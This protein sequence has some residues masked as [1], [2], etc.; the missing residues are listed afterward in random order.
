MT[1]TIL[2][3]AANPKNTPSI[4]LDQ[5]IRDIELGLER[6]H[7]RDEFTLKQKLAARPVDVRRAMLDYQPSIVHF[8]GHGFGEE[9]IVFEDES[10]DSYPVNADVLGEFFELFSDKV[11]C[12]V[13]NACFSEIQANAIS[14]HIPFVVGMKKEIGDP[15]AIEFAVA[16]YDSL[17]AGVSFDVAYRIA[18]NAIQ[19][20]SNSE[21]Q[22]PILIRNPAAPESARASHI[23]N[24]SEMQ[25]V[26]AKV[27][28]LSSTQRR[29]LLEISTRHNTEYE[30]FARSFP[31]LPRSELSYRVKDLIAMGL[32]EFT[33][34]LIKT[35]GPTLPALTRSHAFS[36]IVNDFALL[37]EL[38][39]HQDL[40]NSSGELASL[41]KMLRIK[42]YSD[43]TKENPDLIASLL[44]CEVPWAREQIAKYSELP[45]AVLERLSLDTVDAVRRVIASKPSLPTKVLESLSL[46]NS[47]HIR[48]IVA[49]RPVLPEVVE[50]RLSR[51]IVDAVRRAIAI[52]PGLPAKII[53]SLSLDSS[54]LVRQVVAARSE[55][56]E[57][58]V[59]RLSRDSVDAV[60]IATAKRT[61][62]PKTILEQFI[63]DSSEEVRLAVAKRSDLDSDFLEKLANDTSDEIKKL[64]LGHVN[65]PDTTLITYAKR[66]DER[67]RE[68]ILSRRKLSQ[69]IIDAYSLNNPSLGEHSFLQGVCTRCG[70]TP[71]FI[72]HFK[73]SC[74]AEGKPHRSRWSSF[75]VR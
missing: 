65:C 37:E 12:V 3:L 59:E 19:W 33:T 31:D 40:Y 1:R 32:V 60:R 57:A 41:Y 45:E 34:T 49:A 69:T 10:G 26:F 54:S 9:G 14:R 29:L 36:S 56:A 35:D 63:T 20:S 24:G 5:E 42:R 43:A 8:C 44:S 7:K 27:Y 67:F 62:V 66:N 61:H 55:L 71:A 2:I 64:S 72:I 58:T 75:N 68:T 22:T 28:A 53:E 52:R 21:H 51:D 47:S 17:G 30:S 4:R 16:F 15:A 25:S 13:L 46:D 70:C 39:S 38:L 18:R 73:S 23:H 50:E 6:A 74:R 48:Q 11:E